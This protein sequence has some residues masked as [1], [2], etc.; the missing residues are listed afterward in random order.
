MKLKKEYLILIGVIVALSAY[1]S[2]RSKDQTHFEL[3]ALNQ[4]ENSAINRIVLTTSGNSIELN[5]KDDKWYLGPQAYLANSIKVN[6]MVK[7]AAD[8]TVT[9]LVSESKSYQRYDLDETKKTNLQ[10]MNGKE[11]LRNVD[12]GRVAPTQQHTFVKL[13]GDDNVYHARGNIN[14]TF[15]HTLA[16]LRDQTVLSFEKDAVDTLSIR[17]GDHTL[18]LT[19]KET[20]PEEGKDG[21]A[22]PGAKSK[23]AWLDADGQA[24]DN[25]AVKSLLNSFGNLKCN[26]YMADDVKQNL[27]EATWTVSFKAGEKTHSLSLYTSSAAETTDYPA[28]TTDSEYAFLLTKTRVERYEKQIDKLLKIE[29]PAE[30]KQ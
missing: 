22:K 14:R 3:P 18:S 20:P 1:L 28:A 26:G 11:T 2:M 5:K 6:N 29:S 10:A 30:E 27:K 16:D 25:A 4:V 12:I 24:A 21:E 17:K 19:K 8:L 15:N 9:A 13:D 7:A 23:T